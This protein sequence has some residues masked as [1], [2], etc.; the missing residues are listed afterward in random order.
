MR[1]S[2]VGFEQAGCSAAEVKRV[3]EAREICV[4]GAR[5]CVVAESISRQS[6]VDVGFDGRG[7]GDSGG[8]VAEAALGAAEGHGDV[9]AQRGFPARA[10]RLAFSV[11]SHA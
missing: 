8:E 7:R 10:R 6:L 1:R 11:H 5:R 9:D 3:D 4:E 2:W